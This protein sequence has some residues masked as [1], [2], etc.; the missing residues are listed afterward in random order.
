MR[1]ERRAKKKAAGD[2]PDVSAV[3]CTI[4]TIFCVAGTGSAALT[5]ERKH[6]ERCFVCTGEAKNGLPACEKLDYFVWA[7][8]CAQAAAAAAAAAMY[9]L[10]VSFLSVFSLRTKCNAKHF[11]R[12]WRNWR[13]ASL[14]RL[15]VL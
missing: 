14:N 11:I 1:H 15:C 7:G 5:I 10:T 4:Q 6:G 9:V 8:A 12:R 3:S 13:T 2:G